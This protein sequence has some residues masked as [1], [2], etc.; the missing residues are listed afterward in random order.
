VLG[1][2]QG[3]SWG[4]SDAKTITCFAATAILLPVFVVRSARHPAPLLDLDLFRMRSFTV[5][6][7]AQALYVGSCFGWL[8]LM[9]SFFVDVWRWTPLGAG[10]GLAPGAAIGA[11]LSPF[12]GRLADRIGHRGLIVVGTV[13]GA[14][15]TGW[16]ALNVGSEPNY[17]HDI[18]PGMVLTGIGITAGFA[19]LT[20]A[21]MS[22]VPQRFYSMAGASR[23]TIFQLATAIGIAVA[24]AVVDN[25]GGDSTPNPYK[26][27]WWIAS[28][29]AVAAAMI[30]LVAFPGGRAPRQPEY[31]R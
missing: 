19:T 21:L 2:V 18:L 20:G 5:G 28:A 30:V 31:D 24:V 14:L 29:C 4:W 15:G 26:S 12:A 11:V 27:V 9:P 10:F 7:L 13:A 25:A 23:S 16:W 22:R 6:N 8:V 17:A 1:V 3:Q